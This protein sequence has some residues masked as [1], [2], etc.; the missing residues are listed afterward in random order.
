M[1]KQ[2]LEMAI[3]FSGPYV[4][5]AVAESISGQVVAEGSKL[6]QRREASAITA[7]I[8]QLFEDNKLSLENVSKFTVGSG[9]GSFTGMRIAAAWVSGFTFGKE[10][11]VCRTVPSAFAVAESA[12]LEEGENACIIFDGRNREVIAF[13]VSRKNGELFATG[14]EEILN[15]EQSKKFF[16]E[17]N[18]SKYLCLEY[19]LAAIKLILPQSVSDKLTAFEQVEA[20]HLLQN[21]VKTFDNDLTGLYYIRPSVVTT[22]K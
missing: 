9:P 21:Q 3:D 5:L 19:D 15:Q 16:I 1:D 18:F 6:M 14:L 17:N 7:F 4:N 22:N 8:V 11:V 20:I 12:G 10:N 13:G 2:S